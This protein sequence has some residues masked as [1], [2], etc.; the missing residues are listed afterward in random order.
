MCLTTLINLMRPSCRTCVNKVVL[1]EK[2]VLCQ[3]YAT[4][5][6][7]ETHCPFYKNLRC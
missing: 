7:P 5:H 6:E 2:R 3:A 1:E 4:W